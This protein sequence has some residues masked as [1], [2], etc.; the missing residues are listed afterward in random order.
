MRC[1]D[2]RNFD[3]DAHPPTLATLIMSA[4]EPFVHPALSLFFMT[5]SMATIPNAEDVT[6]MTLGNNPISPACRAN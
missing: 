2:K 1:G 3:V 4:T 6:P 5:P